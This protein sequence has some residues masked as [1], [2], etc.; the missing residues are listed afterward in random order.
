MAT[1][2]FGPK[3]VDAVV[4]SSTFSESHPDVSRRLQSPDVATRMYTLL[5][6]ETILTIAAHHECVHDFWESGDSD[7]VFCSTADLAPVGTRVEKGWLKGCVKLERKQALKTFGAFALYT[8]C[9]RTY[10][11]RREHNYELD[12]HRQSESLRL[13][14]IPTKGS[15]VLPEPVLVRIRLRNTAFISIRT[16]GCVGWKHPGVHPNLRYLYFHLISPTGGELPVPKTEDLQQVSYEEGTDMQPGEAV[17]GVFNLLSYYRPQ[18]SGRYKFVAMHSCAS[19]SNW[20]QFDLH[21]P[22]LFGFQFLK[23][24]STVA[25]P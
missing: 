12:W 16:Y 5:P 2:T 1:F 20:I 9:D 6:A 18:E 22:K 25:P 24:K 14:V 3:A 8:A 21:V 15:F 23:R 13:T 4:F 19:T 10:A 17:T 7:R 11:C